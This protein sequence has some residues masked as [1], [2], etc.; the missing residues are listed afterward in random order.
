MNSRIQKIALTL[1]LVSLPVTATA[2]TDATP[3]VEN[4]AVTTPAESDNVPGNEGGVLTDPDRIENNATTTPA[5]NDGIPGN[6]DDTVAGNAVVVRAEEDNR[7]PWGL[8]GLI[9]LAGLAGRS[10]GARREVKLG[11]PVDGARH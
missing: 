10:G 6:E 9:G 7:F 11:G 1:A 8:L 2:Q 3:N 4:N 5:E